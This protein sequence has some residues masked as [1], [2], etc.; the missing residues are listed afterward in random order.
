MP[1][2]DIERAKSNYN[3]F[4]ELVKKRKEDEAEDLMT[5]EDEREDEEKK[6]KKVRVVKHGKMLHSCQVSDSDLD[7]DGVPDSYLTPGQKD[8][9]EEMDALDKCL[10]EK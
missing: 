9:G 7:S 2:G 6:K 5:M 3:V 8:W 4:N 10:G 1:E